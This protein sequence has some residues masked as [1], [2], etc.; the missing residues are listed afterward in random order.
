MSDITEREEA[1]LMIELK[2]QLL[3]IGLKSLNTV[4]EECA[5][6][7][8]ALEQTVKEIYGSDN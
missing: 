1:L 2:L 8:D 3:E 5:K 6:T 4:I 7:V